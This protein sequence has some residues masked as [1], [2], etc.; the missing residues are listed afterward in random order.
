MGE[1]SRERDLVLAPN[2]HAM[3]LDNTK[4]HVVVYVGP[5][6]TSLSD[7]DRPV[8]FDERTGVFKRCELAE[9]IQRYPSADEGSYMV[10]KNPAVASDDDEH[11]RTGNNNTPKLSFGRTI[12]IAG[13]VTFPLW[14]GQSARVIAGHRLRSNQYV[15]VRI[16]NDEAAKKN[17]TQGVMKKQAP[18]LPTGGD[19]PPK[20]ALPEGAISEKTPEEKV[21]HLTMGQLLVIKGTDVSFYIPPTGVEVVPEQGDRFVR[22]AVTL[23]RLEFCILLDESGNKRFVKG[24]AVVFPEPTEMFVERGKERKFRA[25]ELNPNMGLHIKVIADYQEGDKQYKAGEELFITGKEQTIYFPRPEHMVVKYDDNE[26]HYAVAIPAGE[27]RY[28]LDK[29]KGKV[30]LVKGPSMFLA[31]PR[32][33]V[34]VRRVLDAKSVGLWFPGNA[35]ALSHN[36]LLAALAKEKETEGGGLRKS[37]MVATRSFASAN[38]SMD[39]SVLEAFAGD[40]LERRSAFTP[41]RSITLDNKY[42]GAVAINVWT[43]YAIQVVSKSG[44]RKVVVGPK[45]VLLEYDETLEVLT[46]SSGTPKNYAKPI[47]TAYLLTTNNKVS[48]IIEA[49]TADLVRVSIKL[50]HRVN[51]EGDPDK[52]FNVENYVKLLTDHLRSLVRSTVKQRGIEEFNSN[53]IAIIRDTILGVPEE[54]K[55]RPGRLFEENGMRVYDVEVLDVTIGDERIAELL[56]TAQHNAVKEALNVVSAERTLKTNIRL[57]EVKR[58]TAEE[59]TTTALKDLDL[60]KKRVLAELELQL[61]NIS[62]EAKTI[63]AKLEEEKKRQG[64]MDEITKAKLDRDKMTVDQEYAH[65]ETKQKLEIARIQAEV[66]AVCDKAKAFG[67]DV[68]AA[69]EAFANKDLVGKL[70]ESMAPLPL[71]AGQSM[72]EVIS[73]V[74]QGTILGEAM[75]G[76]EKKQSD[77]K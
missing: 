66:T 47:S 77:K 7:T 67:P 14:P 42:D 13:P 3:I 62:I 74:L 53:S 51:F 33:Q 38:L 1:Q 43:G 6:K 22:E 57:E 19:E 32:T 46:L 41:P 61:S 75:K 27:A 65:L 64:T 25:I 56:M 52:W 8:V 35:E 39:E 48:D 24:P 9:A 76:W 11:P 26:I 5:T 44:E 17:W 45:T 34:I 36:Q 28:V 2:E 49:E 4:G 40:A 72:H 10:L 37:G 16:Y 73:Q 60:K 20:D 18:A 31:D 55:K 12:N 59:A 69:L 23:E 30:E 15:V 50:S 54:G 58:Q 21:E 70:A 71:L 29:D 63:S 68:V